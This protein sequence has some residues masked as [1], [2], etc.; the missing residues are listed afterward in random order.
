[1][2]IYL[3]PLL[4]SKYAQDDDDDRRNDF[5]DFLSGKNGNSDRESRFSR[6]RSA[7]RLYRLAAISAPKKRKNPVLEVDEAICDWFGRSSSGAF[8]DRNREIEIEPAVGL[9]R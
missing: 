3:V 1:M 6:L 4:A 8:R 5:A 7:Q 2:G 9:A